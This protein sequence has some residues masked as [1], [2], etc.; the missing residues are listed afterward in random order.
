[1]YEGCKFLL[2]QTSLC[3]CFIIA[4]LTAMYNSIMERL[5]M[6]TKVAFCSSLIVTLITI[7]IYSMMKRLCMLAQAHNYVYLMNRLYMFMKVTFWISVVE[8]LL[9]NLFNFIMYRLYMFVQI[10]FWSWMIVTLFTTQSWKNSICW[11]RLIFVVN[12]WLHCYEQIVHV[13][14][15]YHLKL[16]YSYIASNYI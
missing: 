14:E 3:S 16:L 10:A 12:L 9:T 8:S 13:C 2:V 4:L 11:Y 15:G 6:L 7:Q 5:Y 1:M